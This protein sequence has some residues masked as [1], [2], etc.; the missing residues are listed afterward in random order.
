MKII[1]GI[2]RYFGGGDS[3]VE[4]EAMRDGVREAYSSAA[5]DPGGKHLSRSAGHLL[6]ALVTPGDLLDDFP[7]AVSESLTGVSNVSVLAEIP[8]GST[9]LDI[10]LVQALTASLRPGKRDK[11][12]KSSG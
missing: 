3:E 4:P 6:K 12:D 11:Q 2:A 8:A 9:V 10:G 5:M 7:C 1:R